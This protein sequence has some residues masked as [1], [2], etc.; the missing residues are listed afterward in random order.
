MS[1]KIPT[2][3]A[4]IFFFLLPCHIPADSLLVQG[5][6]K[7]QNYQFPEGQL[8]F[9][10]ADI[11]EPVRTFYLLNSEYMSLKINGHYAEANEF[12]IE[13]IKEA[14][15]I[16]D[17]AL[18]KNNPEYSKILMYYGALLGLKS[19]V[20]MAE[21]KYLQGYY[22]GLRGFEK[23]KTAYNL[24]TTLTDAL[25]AMG[26]YEFYSGIM[27]QH[28]SVV[29]AAINADKAI[30]SGLDYFWQAWNRGER[31]KAEA[32]HL[33]LLIYVYEM[34]DYPKALRIGEELM[35]EYPG[36]LENRSLYAE[37]LILSGHFDLA[38]KILG[39]FDTYTSWLDKE[40]KRVWDLRKKYIQAVYAMEKG[41]FETAESLFQEVINKYCFEYQWQKNRSLLKIGQMADLQGNR[42]KA[43]RYYQQVVDSKET[44]RAVLE[45][46]KYLKKPYSP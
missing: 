19:Q 7:I 25:L 14:K 39:E 45:A 16:F 26:T 3:T 9:R 15:D 5:V 27:A 20:F 36:N 23:V 22:H 28:Y 37:A 11:P 46:K 32:G 6:H 18:D 2:L 21:N 24:D 12:L 31:S 34:H 17:S 41:D 42:K 43:R 35:T 10:K 29:G 13:G 4:L 33:L 30:R 8:L 40:G 44:T 1:R 38:D